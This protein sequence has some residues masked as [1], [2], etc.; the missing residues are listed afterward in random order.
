MRKVILLALLAP[1][2]ASVAIAPALAETTIIK[3][4]HG[5]FGGRKKVVIKKKHGMGGTTVVKKIIKHDD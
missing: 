5:E 1:L 3:K 4:S 2:A